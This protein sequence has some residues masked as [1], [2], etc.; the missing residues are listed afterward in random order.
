LNPASAVAVALKLPLQPREEVDDHLDELCALADTLGVAVLDRV[1]QS[2]PSPEAA[3]W[4]GKGKAEEIR[5]MADELGCGLIIFD[6]ELSSA[7]IR[8]LEK[9]MERRVI[10]RTEVILDIFAGKA[11][12]YEAKLQVE[13]AQLEFSAT[14]LRH[15][16]SHLEGQR[17]GTGTRGGAGEKQ[18]EVDRRHVKT[19]VAILKKRLQEVRRRRTVQRGA[20]L[21]FPV[22]AVVGY[23]NVGKSTLINRLAGSDL[24][25][26][27][28]L[29]AT[30][31][32]S[33]RRVRVDAHRNVLL[34]DT[35]GFIRKFP[36]QLAASF[37]STIEEA[38]EA[39][40]LVHVAD[41]SHP[42]LR[43]QIETVEKFLEDL[44]AKPK[45]LIRVLNKIDL[46]KKS[47]ELKKRCPP[48]DWLA[49]SAQTGVGLHLFREAVGN[50]I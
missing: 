43:E 5:A 7:Q 35:V 27:N 47:L 33:T 22:G 31:D 3:T 21:G 13:M 10:T 34:T 26:E 15:L 41:A 38:L 1:I 12:T 32:A 9:I 28:K 45:P 48:G 42:K 6:D 37:R 2:R 50:L 11:R 40:F 18:I 24:Y 49:V 14:R 25:T 17:G 8:N 19:R 39:D 20:R 30:L 44:G 23:T 4:I 36:P 16:W 46:V 29:F